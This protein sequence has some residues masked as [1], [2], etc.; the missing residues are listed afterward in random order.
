LFADE[1]V[2]IAETEDNLQKTAHKLNRII[3]EYGL[4]IICAENK[5]NGD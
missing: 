5:I 1:K 3:I 2:I 4:N